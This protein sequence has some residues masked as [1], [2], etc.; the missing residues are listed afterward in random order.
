[1]LYVI[2]YFAKSL[3]VIQNDGGA[4][5]YLE[6]FLR[7][8]ALNNG[9]TLKSGLEVIQGHWSKLVPLESLGTVSYSHSLV[10]TALSCIISEIEIYWPKIAIFAAQCDA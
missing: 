1:M 4:S 3:Q 8:S 10:T 5:P 7:Y 9:V 2:E 6:L